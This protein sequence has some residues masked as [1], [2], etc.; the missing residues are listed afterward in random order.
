MDEQFSQAYKDFILSDEA[1]GLQP[2]NEWSPGD[3][4]Y[5]DGDVHLVVAT[6][7]GVDSIDLIRLYRAG[8]PS[9][10]IRWERRHK[11]TRLPTLWQL[12][13]IIEGA[14]WEWRKFA[15]LVYGWPIDPNAKINA[16][17]PVSFDDKDLML[18]AAKVAARAVEAQDETTTA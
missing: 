5:W 3:Y 6:D 16:E 4:V 15:G 7:P 10:R 13:R 1:K 12:L 14:G 2:P 17:Y 11:W 18:A 8:N 9:W